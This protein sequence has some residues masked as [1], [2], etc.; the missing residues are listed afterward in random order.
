LAQQA[1]AIES[2]PYKSMGEVRR[3]RAMAGSRAT[4]AYRVYLSQ[5]NIHLEEKP[6]QVTS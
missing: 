2:V 4:T 3:R 5:V 1:V 6:G